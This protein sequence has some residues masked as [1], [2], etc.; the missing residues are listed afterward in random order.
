MFENCNS[1]TRATL[2]RFAL[3]NIWL[4]SMILQL[5]INLL[6]ILMYYQACKVCDDDG[7]NCET[8]GQDGTGVESTDF[9]LYV[10]ANTTHPKCSPNSLT[11]AFAVAC[12]LER[13]YDR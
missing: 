9:L 11:L 7:T 3:W 1:P 5:V 4:C 10:S 12:Q 8:I 6:L 13:Q 2:C